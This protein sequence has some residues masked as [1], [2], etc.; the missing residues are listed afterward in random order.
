MSRVLEVSCRTS[1]GTRLPGYERLVRSR[2]FGGGA[3]NPSIADR[4]LCLVFV[5]DNSDC[6]KGR[7]VCDTPPGSSA[8]AALTSSVEGFPFVTR[9]RFVDVVFTQLLKAAQKTT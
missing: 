2:C 3:L 8:L 7:N 4:Y 1:P 9:K 6:P 5:P